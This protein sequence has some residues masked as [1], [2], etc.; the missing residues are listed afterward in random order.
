MVHYSLISCNVGHVNINA[1]CFLRV[2]GS[3]D[4]CSIACGR[5]QL[6]LRVNE[7]SCRLLKLLNGSV[8][9]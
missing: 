1:E 2:S 4:I 3:F 9:F 8:F 5:I 7:S 6:Q